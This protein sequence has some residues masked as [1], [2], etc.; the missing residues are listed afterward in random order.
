[1]YL[2][3]ELSYLAAVDSLGQRPAIMEGVIPQTSHAS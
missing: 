2:E 1:M 3:Y